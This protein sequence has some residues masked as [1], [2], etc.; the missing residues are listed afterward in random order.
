M[1]D[2]DDDN[3]YED[4]NDNEVD[5]DIDG[6]DDDDNGVDDDFFMTMVIM[7]TRRYGQLCRPTSSSCGGLRPSAKGFFCPLG[8][9]KIMLF[10]K[11][12]KNS[13]TFQKY[14]KTK[15][16]SQKIQKNLNKLKKKYI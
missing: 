14:D 8:K 9:K 16:K 3:D 6:Y 4:D 15:K 10:N 13:Q 5:D 7:I 1:D 11:I 2:H 12:V